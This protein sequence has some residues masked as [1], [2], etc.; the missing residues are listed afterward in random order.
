MVNTAMKHYVPEK[1]SIQE[2]RIVVFKVGVAT[3]SGGT[4]VG[5][6]YFEDL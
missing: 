2:D 3:P 4:A 5:Y 6:I 1:E